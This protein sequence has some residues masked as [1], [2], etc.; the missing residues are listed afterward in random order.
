MK[1]S[2]RSED[3]K[4]YID[5]HESDVDAPSCCGVAV[6]PPNGDST[7]GFG[8]GGMARRLLLNLYQML[9]TRLPASERLV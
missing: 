7:P 4:I 1:L 9:Y 5:R 8:L 3:Y 6:E 2:T